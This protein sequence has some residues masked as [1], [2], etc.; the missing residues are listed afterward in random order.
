MI[1]WLGELYGLGERADGVFT[2]GGT[3][4]N[5]MGLLLAR[6]QAAARAGC[7]I[8]RDGVSGAARRLRIVASST[9]HFSVRKSARILGLGDRAVVEVAPEEDGRLDPARVEAVMRDLAAESLIP[10]ALVAT[11]GHHGPRGRSTRS[12]PSARSRAVTARG[13]TSTPPS[14]AHSP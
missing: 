4:S 5:L 7:D 2:S 12:S 11:G 13:S 9:A 8:S 6:D 10:M 1:G 3:Q 14:A